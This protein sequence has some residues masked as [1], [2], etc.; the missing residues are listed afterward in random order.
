MAWSVLGDAIG[1]RRNRPPCFLEQIS[2]GGEK[3][4]R[5]R[6]AEMDVE[7]DVETG[8]SMKEA[9]KERKHAV[10]EATISSRPM[11][12]LVGSETLSKPRTGLGLAELQG[13]R[14]DDRPRTLP[15]CS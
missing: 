5:E 11:V 1:S 8:E 13:R 10:L 9:K 3:M 6:H 14:F 2:R 4:R 7:M 12:G 15:R